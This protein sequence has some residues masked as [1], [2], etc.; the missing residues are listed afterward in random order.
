[1]QR[2]GAKVVNAEKGENGLREEQ[3][4]TGEREVGRRL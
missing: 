2:R 3:V 4:E 1:M